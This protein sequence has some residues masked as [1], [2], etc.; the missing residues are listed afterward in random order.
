MLQ[1]VIKNREDRFHYAGLATKSMTETLKK[2]GQELKGKSEIMS[3]EDNFG[4][5]FRIEEV[6]ID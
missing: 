6:K 4:N 2:I 5:I 1:D 3:N